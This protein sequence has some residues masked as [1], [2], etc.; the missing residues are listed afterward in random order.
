[1]S[2]LQM[3]CEGNVVSSSWWAYPAKDSKVEDEVGGDGVVDGPQHGDAQR[4]QHRCSSEQ[5][6]DGHTLHTPPIQP[7]FPNYTTLPYPTL[8]YPTLLY[9]TAVSS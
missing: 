2:M 3:L 9:T 1:M 8:N 5:L 7:P 4:R 6:P